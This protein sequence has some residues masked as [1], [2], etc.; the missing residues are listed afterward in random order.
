MLAVVCC[1]WGLTAIVVR[2]RLFEL[3]AGYYQTPAYVWSLVKAVTVLYAVWLAEAV[4]THSALRVFGVMFLMSLLGC[5]LL[6]RIALIPARLQGRYQI[7]HSLVNLIIA[8]IAWEDASHAFMHPSSALQGDSDVSPYIIVLGL[9][10]YHVLAFTLT[11]A[12]WRHHWLMIGITLPI[13]TYLPSGRLTGLATFAA[14]GA[15]GAICYAAIAFRKNNLLNRLEEKRI[16]AAVN[17]WFRSPLVTVS[18]YVVFVA[19][20]DRPVDGKLEWISAAIGTCISILIFWN[21]QFYGR[22]VVENY[23]SCIMECKAGKPVPPPTV[24]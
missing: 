19:I 10:T 4:H 23:G 14:C 20:W 22:Q 16:N 7:I 9:H 8:G 21:G 18:G 1:V 12:D 17:T 5:F 11:P 24:C 3:T 15:P 13:V 2:E 6:D